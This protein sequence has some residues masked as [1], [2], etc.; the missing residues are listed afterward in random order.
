[1]RRIAQSLHTFWLKVYQ[2]VSVVQLG[3]MPAP[4]SAACDFI[5]KRP[6]VKSLGFFERYLTVWVFLCIVVGIGLGHWIAGPFEYLRQLEIARVNLPIAVLIWLMVLPM[7]LKI[8]FGALAGVRKHWRGL[9]VALF[10]NWAVKP[11]SIALLAWVFCP[12]SVCTVVAF[13]TD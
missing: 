2:Q 11:V 6:M 3:E 12:S 13:R 1:M 10:A 4:Q 9:G 7:L 8:D 5:R